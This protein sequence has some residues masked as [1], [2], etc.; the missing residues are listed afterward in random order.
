MG[1]NRILKDVFST[2]PPPPP[3]RLCIRPKFLT[4]DVGADCDAGELDVGDVVVVGVHRRYC[5]RRHVL[6]KDKLSIGAK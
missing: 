2:P 3:P 5:R 6:N 4:P 1:Q